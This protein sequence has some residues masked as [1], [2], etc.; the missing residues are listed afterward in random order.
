[1]EFTPFVRIP[2][3][4]DVVEIT[5][6]N[7]AEVASVIGE[8]RTKGDSTFI[9]IDRRLVPNVNRAYVGWFMTKLGDNYRCYSAKAFREQF[10][11]QVCNPITFDLAPVEEE[12]DPT[13]A[14]GTVR[15]DRAYTGE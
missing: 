1:M 4:V 9:A 14:N 2:F 6:D 11:E 5:E 7:I 13:P 10:T 8:L 3:V 15:P 12:S